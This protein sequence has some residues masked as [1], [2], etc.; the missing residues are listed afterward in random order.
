MFSETLPLMGVEI[1]EHEQKETGNPASWPGKIV[2]EGACE[3]SAKDAQVYPETP[4]PRYVISEDL[5]E[6]EL[7]LK[8]VRRK[9]CTHTTQQWTDNAGKTPGCTDKSHVFSTVLEGDDVGDSDLNEL[10]DAT[11]ADTLNCS[12]DYEPYHALRGST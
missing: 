7:A 3:C 5:G 1:E 8:R 4:P 6:N 12:C 11:A 2:R 10:H 9:G